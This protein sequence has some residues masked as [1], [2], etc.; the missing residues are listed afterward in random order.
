MP[1]RT[2]ESLYKV[3]SAVY[4]KMVEEAET[5][6]E[7]ELI[8]TGFVSRVI[9]EITPSQGYYTP[10]RRLLL[11]PA[12]D[13][14]CIVYKRGAGKLPSEWRLMHPPP[15]AWQEIS[16][17]DLTGPRRADKLG[18]DIEQRVTALESLTKPIKEVSLTEIL[19]NFE[20]RIRNLELAD[21]DSK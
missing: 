8:F 7:G 20:T 11:S 19:R 15:D 1:S 5:N 12:E 2:G 16:A 21:T 9:N 3:T 17:L 14:C 6:D 10:I 13:P 18:A 4:A